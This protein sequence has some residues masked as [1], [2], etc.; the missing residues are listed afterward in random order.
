MKTRIVP[1][2]ILA[3]LLGACGGGSPQSTPT[4]NTQATMDA[5]R[6]AN[7]T[8]IA[9]SI[10]TVSPTDTLKPATTINR[11]NPTDTPKPAATTG[12]APRIA[13]DTPK[14]AATT[15]AASRIATDT[16]KPAAT[17]AAAGPLPLTQTLV[18]PNRCLVMRYPDGW[19]VTDGG[20]PDST[21]GNCPG[22]SH[23]AAT[24]VQSV[25]D[26]SLNRSV[27]LVGGVQNAKGS[28]GNQFVVLY[29]ESYRCQQIDDD[30]EQRIKLASS[31][32]QS[33]KIGP[34]YRR[35]IMGV[36]TRCADG[37]Q[38]SSSNSALQF[39]E[40]LFFIGNDAYAI[41][42]GSRNGDTSTVQAIL[43][44]VEVHPVTR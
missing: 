10:P 32:D 15:A 20:I 30:V 19:I 23:F 40:C 18:G 25:C 41:T 28:S 14:P 38:T 27:E 22:G 3:A 21:T 8:I 1:I 39:T 42:A 7:A 37:T 16:P 35:T 2:M 4:V 24:T 34:V 31:E 17:T 9:A 44:T 26:A 13:T 12:V 43:S 33:L 11:V 5:A 29:R 6:D 36:A